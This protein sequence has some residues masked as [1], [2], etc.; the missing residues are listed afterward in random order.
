MNRFTDAYRHRYA[1]KEALSD[2]LASLT[3]E[4]TDRV[5]L[6]VV[7][8]IDEQKRKKGILSLSGYK[9]VKEPN[10]ARNTEYKQ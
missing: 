9:T 2:V 6:E 10:L 1:E 7:F 4:G 3:D 5:G 8:Y